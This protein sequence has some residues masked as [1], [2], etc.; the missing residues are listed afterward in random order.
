MPTFK[1][2]IIASSQH[3]IT[4][5]APIQSQLCKNCKHFQ[6]DFVT[7]VQYGKCKLFGT[8]NLVDGT[9]KYNYASVAR[10][11]MCK[12]HHYEDKPSI[13]ADAIK[14]FA[15]VLKKDQ[16]KPNSQQ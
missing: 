4:P 15:D 7:S 13:Y 10:T 11:Y 6:P 14:Y 1:L 5:Q 12:G 8:Q 16:D 9:I 3:K 2:P